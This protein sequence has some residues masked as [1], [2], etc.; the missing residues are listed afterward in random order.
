[1]KDFVAN[2]LAWRLA[3]RITNKAYVK[4]AVDDIMGRLHASSWK[5]VLA[6]TLDAVPKCPSKL[7]AFAERL[8]YLRRLDPQNELRDMEEEILQACTTCNEEQI[9]TILDKLRR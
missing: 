4:S 7:G 2:A 6:A 1:M 8:E 3:E 5:S 9:R